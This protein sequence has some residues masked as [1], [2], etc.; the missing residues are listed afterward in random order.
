[1]YCYNKGCNASEIAY[2]KFEELGYTNVFELIGGTEEWGE[3][4][5]KLEGTKIKA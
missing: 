5:Y 1:M 2:E 4:G 3:A